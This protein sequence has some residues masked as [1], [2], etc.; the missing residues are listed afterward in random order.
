MRV[1]FTIEPCY[2][3][4]R[5]GRLIVGNSQVSGLGVRGA[6]LHHVAGIDWHAL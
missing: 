1:S 4:F 6:R 5:K 2:L 3:R